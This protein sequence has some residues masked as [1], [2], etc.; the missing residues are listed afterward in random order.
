[1]LR[2]WKPNSSL[3]QQFCHGSSR[4]TV[5]EQP[6]SSHNGGPEL[7]VAWS[8]P[9]HCRLHAKLLPCGR[10]EPRHQQDGSRI[11]RPL[12]QW[13]QLQPDHRHV[14]P[15]SPFCPSY[16]GGSL[17]LVLLLSLHCSGS[18]YQYRPYIRHFV[19]LSVPLHACSQRA[20]APLQTLGRRNGILLIQ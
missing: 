6:S 2:S 11:L 14:N 7:L 10:R 16:V 18:L 13:A 20:T 12:Q 4:S 19:I 17:Y 8:Q 1:M 5:T 15:A 9:L 3:P